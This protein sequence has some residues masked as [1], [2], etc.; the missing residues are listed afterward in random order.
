[1]N[2]N[3]KTITL[4]SLFLNFSVR[5]MEQEQII[6]F[7]TLPD[8][9]RLKVFERLVEDPRDVADKTENGKPVS[10]FKKSFNNFY[11]L[12]RT[13]KN[14]WDFLCT[15]PSLLKLVI[16]RCSFASFINDGLWFIPNPENPNLRL[17]TMSALVQNFFW[18]S[19]GNDPAAFFAGVI[20]VPELHSCKEEKTD[21]LAELQRPQAVKLQALMNTLYGESYDGEGMPVVVDFSLSPN[22]SIKYCLSCYLKHRCGKDCF[23]QNFFYAVG[24]KT[25]ETYS[26]RLGSE[27]ELRLDLTKAKYRDFFVAT[28]IKHNNLHVLS[29]LLKNKVSMSA[30]YEN[31]KKIPLFDAIEVGSVEMIKFLTEKAGASLCEEWHAVEYLEKVDFEGGQIQFAVNCHFSPLLIACMTGDRKMVEYLLEQNLDRK[32]EYFSGGGK[33]DACLLLALLCGHFDI[34]ELLLNTGSDINERVR[35]PCP[36]EL[37]IREVSPLT[38]FVFNTSTSPRCAKRTEIFEFMIKHDVDVHAED[39]GRCTALARALMVGQ[40]DSVKFLL[41]HGCRSLGS[42]YNGEFWYDVYRLAKDHNHVV[43]VEYLQSREDFR[44]WLKIWYRNQVQ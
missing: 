8:E 20:S 14:N 36:A 44:T 10:A 29:H 43:I 16:N 40:L 17:A 28:A 32:N 30:P 2:S 23:L 7:F 31:S 21:F 41:D 26:Q 35:L 34:A 18:G 25:L 19:Y 27:N 33:I 3:F 5:A 13:N 37:G 4:I 22:K 42:A 12:G 9:L 39:N 15:S 11:R 1:M 38:F 24:K 6:P